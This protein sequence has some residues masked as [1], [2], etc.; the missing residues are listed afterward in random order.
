ME[1]TDMKISINEKQEFAVSHNRLAQKDPGVFER[2]LDSLLLFLLHAFVTCFI[3]INYRGTPKK[4]SSG[5]R[6]RAYLRSLQ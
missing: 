6:A 1:G 4:R 3:R 5:K 2:I